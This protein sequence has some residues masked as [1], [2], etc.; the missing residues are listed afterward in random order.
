MRS[1][2]LVVRSLASLALVA[3][4][5]AQD[6]AAAGML[7]QVTARASGRDTLLIS[8]QLV[9]RSSEAIRWLR[10]GAGQACTT[11]V[12]PEQ[13]PT[14]VDGPPGWRG[15]VVIPEES[16]ALHLWWEVEAPERAI[17]AD[18][19]TGAFRI[20]VAAP[21]LVRSELVG[22]DGRRV[23]PID[24]TRLAFVSG[25]AGGRCWEGTARFAA[26]P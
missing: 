4:L 12:I 9:N 17:S 22:N 6:C 13:M 24:F 25:G 5:H 3:P 1:A 18:S 26:P 11:P 15:A 20:R 8:Y 19:G 14:V 7:V 16:A 10:L 23:R 21:H 2:V